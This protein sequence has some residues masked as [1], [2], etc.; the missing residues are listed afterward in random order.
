[1][2]NMTDYM[3]RMVNDFKES[4][5]LDNTAD[6]PARNDLFQKGTG[7]ELS[8]KQ[9]EDFHTFV[10]KGLFACKRARPGIQ[11]A[12][13]VLSTR[14]QQPTTDDWKKLMRLMKYINGMLEF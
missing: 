7:E 12:I 3:T 9:K 13:A 5:K 10:A 4:Y 6:T 8:G 11:T 1:M 2:L 14:V